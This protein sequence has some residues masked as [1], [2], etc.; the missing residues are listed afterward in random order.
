M[1]FPGLTLKQI[2]SRKYRVHRT[3]P[4]LLYLLS[5]HSRPPYPRNFKLILPTCKNTVILL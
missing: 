1:S 3:L 2:K 5:G 4:F